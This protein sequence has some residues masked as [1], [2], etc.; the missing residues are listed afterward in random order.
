M[1]FLTLVA[2]TLRVGIAI[3]SKYELKGAT[4]TVTTVNHQIPE[5]LLIKLKDVSNVS[6]FVNHFLT[7]Y[8]F[9]PPSREVHVAYLF[10]GKDN[11][12]EEKT[13]KPSQDFLIDGIAHPAGCEPE[14]QKIEFPV[15]SDPLTVLWP[16]CTRIKR[17]NGCCSSH[18]LECVP[19][20]N[21]TVSLKVI[22]ARYPKPGA[23]RFEFNGYQTFQMEK[24]EKCTCSCKT[25]AKDCTRFQEYRPG[26]CRCVCKN[27]E[28]MRNCQGEGRVWSNEQCRC[29]CPTYARCSTGLFFNP[30]TCRCQV[31]TGPV[32]GLGFHGMSSNLG[33]AV[34]DDG[35]ENDNYKKRYH[36]INPQGHAGPF[37]LRR[38]KRGNKQSHLRM[39][40]SLFGKKKHQK[41]P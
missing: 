20:S 19:T 26:E 34:I 17:C 10:H 22:K 31:M 2:L 38:V 27:E 11:E 37:S 8:P 39:P 6:E 36:G 1:L 4:T 23:D 28:D 40:S 12:E 9:H 29:N 35:G 21:S 25:K 3:S 14:Y 15:S 7:G 18:L 30:M 33:G 5:T 41:W 16:T 24:H 32:E 13:P